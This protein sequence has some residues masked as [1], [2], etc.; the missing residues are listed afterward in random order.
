MAH[1]EIN[2]QIYSPIINTYGTSDVLRPSISERAVLRSKR[3]Y[4]ICD[5]IWIIVR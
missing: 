2:V 4:R 1:K 5:K 3:I